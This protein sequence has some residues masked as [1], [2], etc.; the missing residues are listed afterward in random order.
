MIIQM[1]YI[2]GTASCIFKTNSLARP[3]RF[4]QQSTQ[5]CDPTVK[6]GLGRDQEH[7]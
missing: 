2:V 1:N 4:T 3:D 7:S 6:V 5:K